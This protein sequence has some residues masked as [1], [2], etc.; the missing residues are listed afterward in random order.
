MLN[1]FKDMLSK[2]ETTFKVYCLK[3]ISI[4][5]MGCL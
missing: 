3:T 5:K 2:H 1:Q 4:I